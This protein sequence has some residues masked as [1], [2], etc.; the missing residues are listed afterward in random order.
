MADKLHIL[1]VFDSY[2]NPVYYFP[3]MDEESGSERDSNLL[4]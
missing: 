1:S 3:L 4:A 2:E